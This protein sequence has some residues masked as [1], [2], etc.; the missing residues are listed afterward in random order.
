[1]TNCEIFLNKLI[2]NNLTLFTMPTYYRLY[3][4]DYNIFLTELT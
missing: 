2:A 1:M 3:N 4:N